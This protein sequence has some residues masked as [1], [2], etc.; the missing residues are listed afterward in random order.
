MNI[1]R[2]IFLVGTATLTAALA[3]AQPVPLLPA[4]PED[5]VATQLSSRIGVGDWPSRHV[6]SAT[7]HHE[8]LLIESGPHKAGLFGADAIGPS[9]PAVDARRIAESRQYWVDAGAAELRFGVDLPLTAS[10]A[11][12]RISVADDVRLRSEQVRL[13]FEGREVAA[14]DLGDRQASGAELQRAGWAVPT[15]TLV[16]ALD[17]KVD[18]GTLELVI[19]DLP[20][21]A[22]A[23]IHVFEPASR[24]VARLELDRQGFVA[25]ETIEA[26]LNLVHPR[27]RTVPQQASLMLASPDGGAGEMLQARAG[28]ASWSISA[29]ERAR[30]TPG[31]LH[32]LQA[33]VDTTI[34]GVRVR[35]DLSHA[36]AVSPALGRLAGTASVERAADLRIG[37]DLAT[38]V[39]GRFQLRGTLH[40]T[41]KRGR[42]T[43]VAVAET[44]AV[45][46]AGAGRLALQFDLER[47]E[48][49]GYHAPFELRDLMLFDQGRMLQLESRQRALVIE[50]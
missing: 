26:R 10:G 21:D 12:V 8:H 30:S 19:D 43:P 5:L 29:P 49:A 40:A 35:R 22:V 45:L 27:G 32:E 2:A 14:R 48:A 47:L 18:A 38:V 25:G 33:H 13:R 41:V 24:Y 39:D 46:G 4:G 31:A 50:R 36:I 44:A 34:N 15:N 42:L 28:T 37:I 7:L 6:E 9:V 3:H 23:L 20:A 1:K 17:R 11:V 16:F